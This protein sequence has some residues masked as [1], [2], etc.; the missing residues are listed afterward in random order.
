MQD[1]FENVPLEMEEID[2]TMWLTQDGEY[3]DIEE[4]SDDE[5]IDIIYTLK[6]KIKLLPEHVN[7]DIWETYLDVMLEES[8]DRGIQEGHFKNHRI[9]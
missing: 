9:Q 5:V 1:I 8:K 2:F 7:I 4:L 6:R 3:E